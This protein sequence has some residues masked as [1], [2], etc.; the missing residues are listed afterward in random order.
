MIRAQEL[1]ESPGELPALPVPN[2][3]YGLCGRKTTL[4]E[5]LVAELRNC[6]KVE[7]HVN[8]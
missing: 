7:V 1:C 4:T 8:K 6:V 2:G 5:R 3:L